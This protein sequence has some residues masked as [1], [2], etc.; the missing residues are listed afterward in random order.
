MRAEAEVIIAGGSVGGCATALHLA[1]RGH[2]VIVLE[3]SEFPREKI[4]GEGL[5][6]HG[7]AA[8]RA[9]G[10]FDAVEAAGARRFRGIAY[11]VP[12]ASAV[13]PF[14]GG[15]YGLGIRRSAL[16]A[17]LAEAASRH[18]KIDYRTGVRVRA[19]TGRPEAM[20][21]ETDA[22]PVRGRYSGRPQH[23]VREK[24]SHAVVRYRPGPGPI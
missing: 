22:G 23:P 18:P 12:G 17:T 7:V 10:L 15:R 2:E 21:V 9:L 3:R 20:T 1:R 11:Y 6:P 4:C 19:V 24:L 5:M 8:L 14:P 13:G 16:D